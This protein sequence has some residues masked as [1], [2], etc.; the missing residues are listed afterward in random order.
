MDGLIEPMNC[1]VSSFRKLVLDK[2]KRGHTLKNLIV[3]S[4]CRCGQPVL[5]SLEGNPSRRDGKRVFYPDEPD[6][7]WSAFRCKKCK[8]PVSKSVPGAEYGN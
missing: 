3:E 6:T 7:G 2:N 4:K 8:E 1:F 5:I